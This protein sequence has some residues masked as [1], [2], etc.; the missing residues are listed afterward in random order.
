MG[1]SANQPPTFPSFALNSSMTLAF[2]S[3]T[4]CPFV[5]GPQTTRWGD[6][7]FP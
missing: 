4:V 5:V 6:A 7:I 2:Q 1:L 3:D